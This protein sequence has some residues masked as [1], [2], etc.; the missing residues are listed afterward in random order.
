MK[1]LIINGP[2]LNMLG[3]RENTH[4]GSQA[5][6]EINEILKKEAKRLNIKLGFFQSNT[7]GEIVSAIHKAVEENIDG[8]IINAGAYTHTSIA[9]RDALLIFNKPFIEVHL[10]NVFAREEFRHIS[11]ISDIALGVISGFKEDSYYL[12]L[13][14]IYRHL[15]KTKA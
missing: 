7:E 8:I 14:A 13:L 12:A 4:Y 6:S 3:K 5:L 9:I 10:S 15:Q 1:V 2:N 11:M